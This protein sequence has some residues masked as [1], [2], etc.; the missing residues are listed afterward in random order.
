[1]KF[2]NKHFIKIKGLFFIYVKNISEILSEFFKQKGTATY[3]IE[4]K[5]MGFFFNH[6]FKQCL[7]LEVF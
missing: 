5:I 3:V 4:Q 2:S 6:Y 7:S 1:M